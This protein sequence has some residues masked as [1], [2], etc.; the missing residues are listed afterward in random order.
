MREPNEIR[1]LRAKLNLSQSQFAK[2]F[3][4]NLKSYQGYEQGRSTPGPATRI[5]LSTIEHMP[6]AVSGAIDKTRPVS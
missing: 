6:S 1:A 3:G 2:R 4:F 5:L